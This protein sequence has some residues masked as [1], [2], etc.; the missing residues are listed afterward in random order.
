[1]NYAKVLNGDYSVFPMEF[2]DQIVFLEC[3]VDQMFIAGIESLTEEEI[4]AFF[5]LL[6]TNLGDLEFVVEGYHA[7]HRLFLARSRSFILT[8]MK[9]AN[10]RLWSDNIIVLQRDDIKVI[11]GKDPILRIA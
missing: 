3:L 11:G 5:G 10:W 7:V 9:T 8:A 1:M 6:C 4:N 2:I